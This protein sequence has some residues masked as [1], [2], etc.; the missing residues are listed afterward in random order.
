MKTVN[1]IKQAL[2]ISVL[3]VALSAC[4]QKVQ[5]GA[6]SSASATQNAGNI[7]SAQYLA[8][9]VLDRVFFDIDQSTL[10]AS[11]MDV[12]RGQ[13]A[14]LKRNS[15][16]AIVVEGHA[17]ERGT[18][19]YNLALGA[20]RASAVRD[21]LI[22]MGASPEQVSTLSYGKERPVSVCSENRCW[23]KNRRAVSVIR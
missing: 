18:R 14:W 17:D 5:D 15:R 16:V 13:A 19:D 3:A 7:G 21:A 6:M 8:T 10:D 23:S 11:S 1:M 9:N 22:S 4:A 12:L 20:R 2:T